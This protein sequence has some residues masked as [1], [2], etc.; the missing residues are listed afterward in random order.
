MSSIL[1]HTNN[2]IQALEISKSSF[3]YDD[4]KW[5]E[6]SSTRFSRNRRSP[7][8]GFCGALH[9]VAIRISE[10]SARNV[11]N[12]STYYYQKGF[13]ALNV[14]ALCDSSYKFLFLFA[15]TPGS[16]HDS[17][18]YATSSLASLISRSNN[19]LPDLY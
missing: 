6:Q 7:I 12:P 2:T 16:M 13:F 5:L 19:G 4:R 11:P 18:V 9:G 14:Q 17:T 1:L 8:S 15:V 10:P 3:P